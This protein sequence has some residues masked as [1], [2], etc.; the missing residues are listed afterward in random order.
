MV[1]GVLISLA[2]TNIGSIAYWLPVGGVDIPR[3]IAWDLII[4]GV[5][6][7]PA[8]IV[9]LDQSTGERREQA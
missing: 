6:F 9:R 7:Y 1:A 2:V 5:M 8:L 3:A 4:L